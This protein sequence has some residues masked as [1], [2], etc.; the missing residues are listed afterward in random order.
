MREHIEFVVPDGVENQCG[1][2]RWI[3]PGV[4]KFSGLCSKDTRR[5][6]GVQR[7]GLTVP[8]ASIACAIADARTNIAGTYYGYTYPER[9]TCIDSPSDMLTTA[10]LL[11]E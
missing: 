2:I 1:D 5:A 7:W 6:R 9:L 11:V 4:S 8:H 3:K 10:N